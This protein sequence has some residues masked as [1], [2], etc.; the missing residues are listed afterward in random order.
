MNKK[1]R[2][3]YIGETSVNTTSKMRLDTLREMGHNV[4]EVNTSPSEGPRGFKH[5]LYRL[6]NQFGYP[7]DIAGANKKVLQHSHG[8]H[9]DIVWIDSIRNIS[10]KTLQ[11]F[12]CRC[13]EA[14]LVSFIM[15]DPFTNVGAS[16]QRFLQAASYYDLHFVIRDENILELKNV[17]AKQVY[18]YH[19]GFYPKVHRPVSLSLTESPSYDVF[20]AGHYEPK[21]EADIAFLIE[22]GISVTVAHHKHYGWKKGHYWNIIKPH[23][24]EGGFYGDDYAKALCS[25]KI[26]LCF[27]CQANR[28]KE[29]SRMYEI[30]ACG[31][32]MLAERNSEN[33]KMFEEHKE[34]KFFSSQQE[35]LEKTKYYLTHSKERDQIAAAGRERCLKSGYSYNKRLAWMLQIVNELKEK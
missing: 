7:M 12:R 24:I 4:C 11:A 9:F 20:F 28:D 23:F 19:K 2:I 17:R 16:W 15:D 14:L 8:G 22:H 13:P 6:S 32:F 34:A 31:T 33:I 29:N 3:L 27:Y 35:L 30:P 18:R 26:A 21:R 5:F 10:R 1:L 25:A